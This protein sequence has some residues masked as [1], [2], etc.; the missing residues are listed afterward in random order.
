MIYEIFQSQA[1]CSTRP[2]TQNLIFFYKSTTIILQK[3]KL[4]IYCHI[5]NC[6]SSVSDPPPL[7]TPIRSEVIGHMRN[8]VCYILAIIQKVPDVS[9][10][11]EFRKYWKTRVV[12]QFIIL[13]YIIIL[14]ANSTFTV[15]YY[16]DIILAV[17]NLNT[18]Y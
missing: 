12:R 17:I 15:L 5:F 11:V 16:K 8:I 6:L 2:P 4:I 13:Y 10:M 1:Q 7:P 18:H 9:Y 14:Y 3:F